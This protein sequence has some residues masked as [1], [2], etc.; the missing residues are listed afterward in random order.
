MTLDGWGKQCFYS[1]KGQIKVLQLSDWSSNNK[2]FKN[3]KQKA[4]TLVRNVYSILVVTQR[5][6]LLKLYYTNKIALLC[7]CRYISTSAY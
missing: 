1:H 5:I 4:K 3:V 7:I 6:T 2:T